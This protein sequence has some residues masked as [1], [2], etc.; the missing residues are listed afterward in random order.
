M[1]ARASSHATFLLELA[2][3]QTG[4]KEI[5]K[6]QLHRL[7]ADGTW[8]VFGFGLFIRA[9]DIEHE[10]PTLPLFQELG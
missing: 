3:H 8:V 5:S 1:N 7:I 4:I 2:E 9:S 10:N 6:L